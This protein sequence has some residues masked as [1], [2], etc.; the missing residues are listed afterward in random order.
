MTISFLN[1]TGTLD[2]LWWYCPLLKPKNIFFNQ[3]KMLETKQYFPKTKMKQKNPLKAEKKTNH[4]QNKTPHHKNKLTGVIGPLDESLGCSV[5]FPLL[6]HMMQ[7]KN[8]CKKCSLL[9][10]WSFKDLE[11]PF[12]HFSQGK[13]HYHYCFCFFP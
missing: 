4:I 8:R 13:L 12:I 5:S 6:F 9:F 7:K 1:E 2:L 10:I 3:S 11:P